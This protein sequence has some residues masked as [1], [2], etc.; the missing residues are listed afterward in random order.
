MIGFAFFLGICSS[1]L[2]T[3]SLYVRSRVS[4]YNKVSLLGYVSWIQYAARLLIVITMAI[5]VFGFEAKLF[6]D[7][8]LFI[9]IMALGSFFAM[10]IQIKSE[11]I[12]N[13]ITRLTILFCYLNYKDETYRNYWSRSEGI[14][15]KTIVVSIIIY[16]FLFIAS[17]FPLL[18]ADKY[19]EYRMTLS[20]LAQ[21]GNFLGTVLFIALLEPHYLRKVEAKQESAVAFGMIYGRLISLAF[22][23]LVLFMVK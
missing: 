12:S 21:V 17:Y 8:K 4:F 20:V 10:I 14:C 3:Q 6:I 15:K 11:K 2:E 19:P 18:V 13:I 16:S 5:L 23:S 22:I 1:I 9:L 7:I